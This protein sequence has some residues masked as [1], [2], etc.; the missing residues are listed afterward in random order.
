[1]TPEEIGLEGPQAYCLQPGQRVEEEQAPNNPTTNNF[2]VCHS[3]R[4]GSRKKEKM[5]AQISGS[6]NNGQKKMPTNHKR[7]V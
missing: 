5:P 6:F 2:R 7:G 1:M 4:E 3:R